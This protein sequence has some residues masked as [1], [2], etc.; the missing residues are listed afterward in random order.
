MIVR[1][2]FD[3]IENCSVYVVSGSLLELL[4]ADGVR[5]RRRG[6]GVEKKVPGE[7]AMKKMRIMGTPIIFCA[8]YG[9]SGR[10]RLACNLFSYW[11]SNFWKIL[12]SGAPVC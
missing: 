1:Q 12:A 11:D 9:F 2:S 4:D 6:F 5:G 3:S 7:L 8:F 10:P